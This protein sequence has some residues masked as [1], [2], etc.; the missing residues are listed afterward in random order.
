MHLIQAV[1]GGLVTKI[2]NVTRGRPALTFKNIKDVY[3]AADAKNHSLFPPVCPTESLSF[4]SDSFEVKRAC[5][6]MVDRRTI[7][8]ELKTFDSCCN[9][10]DKRI[11]CD[12]D[13]LGLSSMTLKQLKERCIA[14]KRKR[15]RCIGLSTETAQTSYCV[16]QEEED[17]DL[18]E[19]LSSWRSKKSKNMKAKQKCMK[20]HVSTLSQGAKS[21]VKAEQVSNDE[22]LPQSSSDF[23]AI[24]VKVEVPKPDSLDHQNLRCVDGEP[25][26]LFEEPEGSCQMFFGELHMTANKCGSQTQDSLSPKK[27]L[28]CRVT[29]NICHGYMETTD[30]NSFQIV[31]ASVG[32]SMKVNNPETIS[33]QCSN[34]PVQ[35]PEP[36]IVGSAHEV[37]SD[38]CPETTSSMGN[39]SCLILGISPSSSPMNSRLLQNNNDIKVPTDEVMLQSSGDM[40]PSINIGVAVSEPDSSGH[41]NF[42]S[43]DGD[44]YLLCDEPEGSYDNVSN[45]PY[46]TTRE[47]VLEKWVS[48]SL[49]E[50]LPYSVTNEARYEYIELTDPKSVQIARVS[51]QASTEE[52][53]RE[54]TIHECS[55]LAVPVSVGELHNHSSLSDD[56]PETISSTADH[57]SLRSCIFQNR[58]P[59]NQVSSQINNDING[60][61][62]CM[63]IHKKAR[64][65]ELGYGGDG[66]APEESIASKLPSNFKDSVIATS[67]DDDSL[68]PDW[69][70]VEDDSPKAEVKQL[71]KSACANADINLSAGVDPFDAA[72]AIR[73]SVG[74]GYLHH[75]NS[76]HPPERLFPTRKAISPTSQERL[77][78]AMDS[79]QSTGNEYYKCRGESYFG[80]IKFDRVE[81]HDLG[82]AEFSVSP[83]QIT[84][85]K[86]NVKRGLPPKGVHKVP[87]L[88]CAVPPRF[89]TGCTSI[90]RCTQSAIEFSQQQMKDFEF[91]ATKLTKELRSMKDILE[92]RLLPEDC[93]A[94]SLKYDMDRARMATK[95]AARVEESTRRW[96]SMMARDCNRF[97]KIMALTKKGSGSSGIV[98]QKKST[99]AG[100]VSVDPLQRLA[101]TGAASSANVLSKERKKITF[102]DEA[103]GKLCHVRV[104][105]E[106]VASLSESN[107]E[108]HEPLVN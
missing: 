48:I 55:E 15:P 51:G 81:G 94:S 10:G 23:P 73:T 11:N 61:V 25:A 64:G 105:E 4:D 71:R 79:M 24:N 82:G 91:L 59:M 34:L 47:C 83:P 67:T 8:R 7:K 103:G 80:K 62:H 88:S 33:P 72:D 63:T 44:P 77:L 35:V 93:P 101:E 106:D 19:P 54:T 74:F 99:F 30:Q 18:K 90:E 100:E 102:A 43:I 40:Q 56:S 87:Y 49:T 85:K 78:K 89:S 5:L 37:P 52:D 6:D 26:L 28:K 76:Q 39:H 17:L 104:F 96:I 92:E 3:E 1:K 32:D 65:V 29:N 107:T 2:P 86:R 41:Q 57:S 16:K 60:Q 12:L 50:E 22:V 21:L 42:M 69:D 27:E 98:V 97:C 70:S 45:T 13:D 53:N 84:R 75:S 68:T 108:K 20:D 38:I 31:R 46:E 66:Y 14:K 58:S 9:G 36:E 95:N